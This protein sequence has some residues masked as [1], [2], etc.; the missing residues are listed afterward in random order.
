MSP[1]QHK[2]KPVLGDGPE[3]PRYLL[4]G[5]NGQAQVHFGGRRTAT[6]PRGQPGSGQQEVP[7]AEDAWRPGPQGSGCGLQPGCRGRA[8]ASLWAAQQ[9]RGAGGRPPRRAG[10][11]LPGGRTAPVIPV[12]DHRCPHGAR[13]GPTARRWHC[14]SP[15][16]RGGHGAQ[17]SG[18]GPDLGPADPNAVLSCPGLAHPPGGNDPAS[19]GAPPRDC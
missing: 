10:P 19:L 15:P 12:P 16:D 9:P 1:A 4:V 7:Q 2:H 18:W 5:R 14:C 11:L 3:T 6:R 17:R 8:L 13:A